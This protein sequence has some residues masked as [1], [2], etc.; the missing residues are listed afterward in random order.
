[1]VS[2]ITTHPEEATKKLLGVLP[3]RMKDI[4][5]LRFGLARTAS[6]MTLEAIGDKYGITRERV[7]Q[8]E[9]DAFSRM[10]K[11]PQMQ[12]LQ[13]LFGELEQHFM[14]HGGVLKEEAALASLAPHNKFE[15]HIY[16]LLAIHKPFSR[17]HES[18]DYHA[19]WTSGKGADEQAQ[20]VISHAVGEVKKIGKPITEP[21]LFEVLAASAKTITGA[22]Q[23]QTVLAQWLGVSKRIAKNHFGEWG[24]IDFPTIKPRGVRDLSYMVMSKKAEPMHF[25]A[26]AK[27]IADLVGKK[28]HIQTVHNELIKDN[29]FVLVGRGLYGLRE[30]GFEEGTVKDIV[31]RI[32]KEQGPLSKDNIVSLVCAKRFVKP[33]TIA[34]NLDNKKF[35]KK[36]GDGRYSLK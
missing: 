26:V 6:R 5:E 23:P 35:F 11:S 2:P 33:N 17:F 15:N 31:S 13:G 4:I 29:R 8:I 34:V 28:V 14:A 7:R 9:A 22:P 27:A 36:L 30:W 21:A 25:S 32:L 24:L 1:M 12:D 3:K 19:R 16:F 20:K 18:D 10:Q